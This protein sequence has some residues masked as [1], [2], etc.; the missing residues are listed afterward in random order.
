MTENR[1]K[2]RNKNKRQKIQNEMKPHYS[3][4]FETKFIKFERSTK[5]NRHHQAHHQYNRKGKLKHQ[6]QTRKKLSQQGLRQIERKCNGQ[7]ERGKAGTKNYFAKKWKCDRH[8][9]YSHHQIKEKMQ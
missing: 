8:S 6:Q 5:D 2:T 9:K 7:R 4:V 3:L 1:K